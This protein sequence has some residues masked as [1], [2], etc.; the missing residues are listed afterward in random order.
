MMSSLEN[1]E[2]L[3]MAILDAFMNMKQPYEEPLAEILYLKLEQDVL[4][5]SNTD[6]NE[7]EDDI[8]NNG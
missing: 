3:D 8:F 1:I 6:F 5:V 2:R 4:T 7:D